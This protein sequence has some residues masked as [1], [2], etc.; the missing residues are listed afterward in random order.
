MGAIRLRHGDVP[1][2][3]EAFDQTL[4]RVPSHLFA[5][6]ARTRLAGGS[7][8]S[9]P[10]DDA[11][12]AALARGASVDAAIAGA[13]DATLHGDHH[14]AAAITAEALAAAPP[15]SAGWVVPVEPLL[16]VAARPEIWAPVL[17]RLRN[18]AA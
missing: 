1:G 7:G 12:N 13:I 15:G 11:M 14:R 9:A 18:R 16:D 2:A 8:A 4:H 17:A 10:V 3:H 6:V 5:I